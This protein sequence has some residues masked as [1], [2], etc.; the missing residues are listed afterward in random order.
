MAIPFTVGEGG[1]QAEGVHGCRRE[2]R[3]E[4][5]EIH[6][7][8]RGNARKALFEDVVN[9]AR[10]HRTIWRRRNCTPS[11]VD[12]VLR[13]DKMMSMLLELGLTSKK[14]VIELQ[15]DKAAAISFVVS[16]RTQRL[17]DPAVGEG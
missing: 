7:W 9:N 12:E 1:D 5:K 16:C 17:Q 13:M 11:M 2:W 6:V 8:R 4:V 14:Y 15:T 3:Q 10:N